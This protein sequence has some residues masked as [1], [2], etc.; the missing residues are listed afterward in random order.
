MRDCMPSAGLAAYGHPYA[1][2]LP[3][4]VNHKTGL[5]IS[6]SMRGVKWSASSPKFGTCITCRFT[7]KAY[8]PYWDFLTDSRTVYVDVFFNFELYKFLVRSVDQQ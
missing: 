6:I 2:Q 4:Y 7:L 3:G 5:C 8:Y 1:E